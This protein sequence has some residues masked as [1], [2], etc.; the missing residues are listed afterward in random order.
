MVKTILKVASFLALLIMVGSDAYA[1]PPLICAQI[2]D[3]PTV[4]GPAGPR[5]PQGPRGPAGARGAV[6]NR[7]LAGPAGPQGAMGPAGPAD[8]VY[9]VVNT[10]NYLCSPRFQEIIDQ[11]GDAA[12]NNL[13]FFGADKCYTEQLRA[14]IPGN[15]IC[16]A[17]DAALAY[18]GENL[19]S[20]S[21]LI[22]VGGRVFV[23]TIINNQTAPRGF[24]RT[25]V[26]RVTTCADTSTVL[27]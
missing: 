18:R 11:Y 9:F 19:N 8:N 25:P 14:A 10:E 2:K 20:F 27:Q 23:V 15:P 12:P 1:A 22:N 5:G 13:V 6:G 17:A 4:R 24:V 21:G 7:G 26:K 16:Q 3:C